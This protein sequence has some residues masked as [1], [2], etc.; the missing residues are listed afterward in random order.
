MKNSLRS[1]AFTL[2]FTASAFSAATVQVFNGDPPGT[3]F[4]DPT[5]AA[6]VGGNPG[7]T[8]GAQRQIAFQFAANRW[9][10]TL[11]STQVIRV[12]AL[13]TPLPCNAASAVLGAATPYWFFA[14]EPGLKR[15]TWYPGPLAEKITGVDIAA[16]FPTDNFEIFAIFN[17]QLGQPGCLTGGGFYYGLDTNTPAGLTN[18]VAVLLHELGHGL[19]FLAGPTDEATGARAANIPSVWEQFI[20][21][22]T[23]DRTWL[24]MT[25]PQRAASALKTN[26]LVWQG[27]RTTLTAFEVLRPRTDL[28]VY[29][30]KLFGPHESQPAA[31]GRELNFLGLTGILVA[32][33]DTGGPSL[34]DA[35]EPLSED[36]RQRVRGRIVLVDRGIC[37]FTVKVKNAQN[38]GAVGVIVAN[39]VPVGLPAMGGT[40]PTITIPSIG[41]SQSLANA[42]RALPQLDSPGDSGILVTMHEN[43]ILRAGTTNGLVRLY[44]PNPFEPGS[45]V[46]HFDTSLAPNQLME[47]FINSDLTHSV[48]PPKDLTFSLLRDIGW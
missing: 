13:I 3:G 41:I 18:F 24:N 43:A 39:N 42:L 35:C 2:M 34:T 29:T 37:A 28:L 31:F 19:G 36:R 14:N 23:T 21:D 38:A 32:P 47:P 27:P 5:P 9:G 16:V 6:P 33:V 17:S 44:A 48:T 40:D 10:Q 4:N 15:D 46:S 8:I 7:T 20:R 12:L 1:L 45:S 25:D 26:N 30:S 22:T 11:T